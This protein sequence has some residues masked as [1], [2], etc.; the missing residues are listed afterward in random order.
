M[1]TVQKL[2][3]KQEEAAVLVAEDELTNDEIAAKVKIT[4]RTLTT[5]KH[6]PA[7]M[8]RVDETV[9]EMAKAAQR[10][11]I[12]RVEKRMA[13]RDRDW[14]K[15]QQVIEERAREAVAQQS[16]NQVL[17]EK[18]RAQGT[19]EAQ[20]E[21]MFRDQ[22]H[23]AA[24]METGHVVRI[25]TPSKFGTV[26]EYKFDQSITAELRALED[27]ATKD[28]GQF[29]QRLDVTTG[30]KPLAL[31]LDLSVLSEDELDRR[32]ALSQGRETPQAVPV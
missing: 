20:I 1:S 8:L 15:L 28:A 19:D 21:W 30:G 31:G 17:I 23:V 10:Y 29:V 13:R 11:A 9:T 16:V 27:A 5:W 14:R 2:S 12:A 18:A 3:T 22:P 32:L 25:E 6:L 26:V 4:D 7:F 24:G